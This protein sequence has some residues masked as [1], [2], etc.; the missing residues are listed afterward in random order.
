MINRK[1][2]D[3]DVE[4]ILCRWYWIKETNCMITCD[5]KFMNGL[6]SDGESRS[7]LVT[8][9]GYKLVKAAILDFPP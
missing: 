4:E 1:V 5:E 8:K 7:S 2:Q 9:L 6:I 3:L